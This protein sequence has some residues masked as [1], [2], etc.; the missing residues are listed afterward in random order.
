MRKR[1]RFVF[2]PRNVIFVEMS[3]DDEIKIHFVNNEF[4]VLKATSKAE[5]LEFFNTIKK[6][7]L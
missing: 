4:I 6:S 3:G 2:N 7:R 5:Q 1:P